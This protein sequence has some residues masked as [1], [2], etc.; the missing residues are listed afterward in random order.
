[1]QGRPPRG[2]VRIAGR[3]LVV[4][5]L[6]VLM[7][8]GALL[9]GAHPADAQIV[10]LSDSFNTGTLNTRLWCYAEDSG[11]SSAATVDTVGAGHG[12]VLRFVVSPGMQQEIGSRYNLPILSTDLEALELTVQIRL[13]NAGS[14]FFIQPGEKVAQ[15]AP[16]VSGCLTTAPTALRSIPWVDYQAAQEDSPFKG[17]RVGIAKPVGSDEPTFDQYTI[18]ASLT[19]GRWY[20]LR[21]VYTKTS[22]AFYLDGAQLFQTGK[23]YTAFSSVTDVLCV[24]GGG[25]SHGHAPCDVDFDNLVLSVSNA[26]LSGGD[27]NGDGR[28]DSLDAKLCKKLALGIL[29]GTLAQRREADVNGDGV[30]TNADVHLL[31]QY[32]AA[33]WNTHP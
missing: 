29:I 11:G 31:Q 19:V 23:V 6:F 10:L 15:H 21:L 26:F 28:V 13:N 7:F 1:M 2:G 32:V 17:F 24:L 30:V 9:A 25:D 3:G 12:D 20:T 5:C 14:T 22:F 8:G 33:M 18:P 16:G 4:V 27:V